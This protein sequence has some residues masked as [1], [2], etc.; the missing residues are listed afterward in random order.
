[1]QQ[2]EVTFTAAVSNCDA[3]LRA[4]RTMFTRVSGR[5]LKK[6]LKNDKDPRFFIK[7]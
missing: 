7:A 3:A 1:M 5:T 4:H 2:P 6:Y